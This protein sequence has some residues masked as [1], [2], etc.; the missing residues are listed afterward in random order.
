MKT[1]Q[2]QCFYSKVNK[3][4]LESMVLSISVNPVNNLMALGLW[5]NKPILLFQA[6]EKY[7][8]Y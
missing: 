4:Q 7:F 1:S 3:F 6:W 5:E 2:S 8:K